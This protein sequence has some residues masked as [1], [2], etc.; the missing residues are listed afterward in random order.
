M[1]MDTQ[2]AETLKQGYAANTWLINH[3]T[4]GLTH[5]ESVL[6]L[7]FPANCLNWVLG[8]IINGRNTALELLG[9][10]TVWDEELGDRYR[11]GSEPITS[12]EQARVLADLLQNLEQAQAALE[13]ALERCP[14]SELERLVETE[15]G[16]KPRW[17]HLAGLSWHETYH[18]GQLEIFRALAL[19]QRGPSDG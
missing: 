14:P 10:K 15:R 12:L 13:M 6:Q 5:A 8:H 7:P 11:S 3:L 18:I 4:E 17:E 19:A 9:A 1:T 16:E 2:R